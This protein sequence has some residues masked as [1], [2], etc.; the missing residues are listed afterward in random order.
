M[1]LKLVVALGVV[2]VVAGLYF[3][4]GDCERT[5]FLSSSPDGAYAAE[6][7]VSGICGG[8]TVGFVTD[9]ALAPRGSGAWVRRRGTVLTVRGT[10]EWSAQWTGPR[11]LVIRSKQRSREEKPV[12]QLMRWR[13]VDIT[14]VAD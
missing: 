7:T 12:H 1:Q 10:A 4:C 5:T 11:R 3:G 8:A 9:V 14:Y 13:D 2:I 6:A